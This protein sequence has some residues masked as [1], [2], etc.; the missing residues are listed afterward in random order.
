MNNFTPSCP[1]SIPPFGGLIRMTL[2]LKV[3]QL[4]DLGGGQAGDLGGGQ[5]WDFRG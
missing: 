3:P 1:P 4:G 5:A 2:G